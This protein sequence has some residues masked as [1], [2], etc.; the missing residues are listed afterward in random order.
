M[1]KL[2]AAVVALLIPLAGYASEPPS[3]LPKLT[4]HSL[5]EGS[6]AKFGEFDWGGHPVLATRTEGIPATYFQFFNEPLVW[7]W[8]VKDTDLPRKPV[9]IAFDPKVSNRV[10]LMVTALPG[11]VVRKKIIPQDFDVRTL[12]SSIEINCSERKSRVSSIA[13]YSGYFGSGKQK[14]NNMTNEPYTVIVPGSLID[15]AANI[16]CFKAQ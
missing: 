11:K 1:K 5:G 4:W 6:H 7:T 15:S 8:V 3:W 2:A 9:F 12:I 16:A 10:W 14:H 13:S